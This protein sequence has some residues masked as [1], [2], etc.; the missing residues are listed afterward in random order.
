MHGDM[1]ALGGKRVL[2]AY[3]LHSPWEVNRLEWELREWGRCVQGALSR[4]TRGPRLYHN[5]HVKHFSSWSQGFGYGDRDDVAVV[6]T[7]LVASFSLS[8]NLVL[9]RRGRCNRYFSLTTRTVGPSK[10]RRTAA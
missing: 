7:K 9:V 6:A 1:P 10:E 5:G 4:T 2:V 3:L 8:A